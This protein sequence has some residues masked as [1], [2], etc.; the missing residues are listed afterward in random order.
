MRATAF[1]ANSSA[2]SIAKQFHRVL[3]LSALFVTASLNSFAQIAVSPA[4]LTFA[5]QLI[6]TTST[7]KPVTITNNG[8][9]AQAVNIVMSGDYTETDTC[10]G[11]IA[12]GGGSCTAHIF[13]TP[14]LVGSIKGAA[15]IYDNSK[16][17]LAFV[18]LTGTGG[19]PVTTAPTSQFHRRDDREAERSQ[20]L[21]DHQ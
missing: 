20:D 5:K 14:T 7:S 19:A 15:S 3:L 16:N 12:G 8:A 1:A 4:S 6:D 9:S 13:F 21:Q 10:G 18:G 11:S 17:L 2:S